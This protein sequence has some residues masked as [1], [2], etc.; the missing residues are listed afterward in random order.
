MKSA[1]KKGLVS[2]IQS[3]CTKVF[4]SDN[5]INKERSYLKKVGLH[6]MQ[7]VLGGLL[8][9]Q[10]QSNN[11][12]AATITW[13]VS[14]ITGNDTDV[15]TEGTLV[16][17]HAGSDLGTP[18]T[19]DGYTF[20]ING[21]TFDDGFTIDSPTHYD[22][23]GVR[24]G[25]GISSPSPYNTLLVAA[26]RKFSGVATVTFSD[27]NI[28]SDY[29]VQVWHTDAGVQPNPELWA[30]E[31][32][33]VLNAG[34][35]TPNPNPSTSGHATLISEVSQTSLDVGG[36]PGQY[37]IGRFTADSAT[38]QFLARRW[39]DLSGTPE[40]FTQTFLNAVQLRDLTQVPEPS[41]YALLGG[42]VAI[43]AFSRRK[44]RIKTR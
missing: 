43:I 42:F 33:V 17:A 21:V 22:S 39:K 18:D 23:I 1:S 41:T 32:G 2:L 14:D 28:G 11:L 30:G 37:A 25:A 8:M 13:T 9:L 24:V 19:V 16:E 31:V 3:Q 6:L 44:R 29:L 26:D 10:P 20:M 36:D 15:S 34:G 12:L 35:A 4:M 5:K 38:Q 40:A 7:V 27:L